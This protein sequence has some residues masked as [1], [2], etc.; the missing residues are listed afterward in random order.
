MGAAQ[1]EGEE[2][3]GTRVC[4]GAGEGCKQKGEGADIQKGVQKVRWRR[5]RSFDCLHNTQL[6]R[7]PAALRTWLQCCC[8]LAS[9][10]WTLFIQR[11]R[12]VPQ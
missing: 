8:T 5:R 9:H 10:L 3:R 6:T 7:V 2:G 4:E 11:I 1:E 12:I